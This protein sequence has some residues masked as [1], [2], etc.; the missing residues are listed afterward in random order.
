MGDT[1]IKGDEMRCDACG[2]KLYDINEPCPNCLPS[3]AWRPPTRPVGA[4]P[5]PECKYCCG[6]GLEDSGAPDPQ[7]YYIEIRCRCTLGA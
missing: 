6:T 1:M 3:V 4:K 2:T 5:N 7:G